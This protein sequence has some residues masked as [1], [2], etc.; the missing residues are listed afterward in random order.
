VALGGVAAVG[1]TGAAV[2]LLGFLV[3]P[4]AILVLFVVAS[5]VAD[6]L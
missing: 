3:A 1:L 4:L 5:S 2:A 6:R